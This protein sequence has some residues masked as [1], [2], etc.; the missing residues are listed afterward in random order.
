MMDLGFCFPSDNK[1]TNFLL[2]FST[3]EFTYFNFNKPD[4]SKANGFEILLI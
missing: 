3:S 2:I 1:L 4:S